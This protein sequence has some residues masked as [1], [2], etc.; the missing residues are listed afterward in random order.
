M[1][2]ARLLF[3]IIEKSWTRVSAMHI[4]IVMKIHQWNCNAI[5]VDVIFQLV[6]NVPL[7]HL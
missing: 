5:D 3:Y 1:G 2:G 7:E 6:T 4:A